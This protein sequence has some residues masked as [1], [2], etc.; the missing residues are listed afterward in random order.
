MSEREREREGERERERQRETET[1]TERQRDRETER[2]RDNVAAFSEYVSFL[3]TVSRQLSAVVF[4]FLSLTQPNNCLVC[5]FVQICY[6]VCSLTLVKKDSGPGCILHTTYKILLVAQ[7][8]KI[9][10]LVFAQ[11]IKCTSFI[12]RA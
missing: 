10:N 2:Q 4:I 8:E 9:L 3:A 12:R 11:F 5:W 6:T 7:N 1:E